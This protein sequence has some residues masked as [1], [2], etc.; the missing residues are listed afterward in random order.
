MCRFV[1]GDSLKKFLIIFALMFMLTGCAEV[2]K[3]ST[4]EPVNVSMFKQ[5]EMTNGWR[6]VYHR[7]TKVMYAVSCSTYNYGN[8]TLLVN[9]DGTPML[10]E[11]EDD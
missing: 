3:E 9:P 4:P 11:G 7:E 6:I 5:I 10:Y 8:F 1:G 2:E